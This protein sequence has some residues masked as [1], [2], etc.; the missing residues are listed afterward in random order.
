MSLC[1]QQK[2]LFIKVFEF[3]FS[4]SK[5]TMIIDCISFCQTPHSFFYQIIVFLVQTAEHNLQVI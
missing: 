3:F 5:F 2:K 4:S 1:M